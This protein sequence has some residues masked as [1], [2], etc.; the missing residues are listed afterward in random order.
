MDLVEEISCAYGLNNMKPI[1]P[2]VA[3]IG[4]IH[5]I[6]KKA[7]KARRTMAGL[8]FQEILTFILSN[9]KT[10]DDC[11]EETVDLKNYQSDEY[12]CVRNSLIPKLVEFLQKNKHYEMPQKVFECGEVL[13]VTNKGEEKTESPK[14][15]AAAITSNDVGFTEIKSICE[16]L[17]RN[18]RINADYKPIN[19]AKFI[20]GR[21]AEII[22]REKDRKIGVIGEI[23]PEVLSKF[24]LENPVAVFEINV[25][26]LL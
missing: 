9:K 11:H 26:K 21:A 10:F 6:E 3:T 16:A 13:L 8:G 7:Q 23:N 25:E 1:L 2:N 19:D 14:H 12:N 18:M 20:N 17:L 4:E 22:D 24:Q 5:K 15:L